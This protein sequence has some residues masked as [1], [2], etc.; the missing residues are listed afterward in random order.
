MDALDLLLTRE[1]ALKLAAPG[2]SQADLDAMFQSAVRAPDHGRLR[3]WHFV[4]IDTDRRAAFGELMAQS[5][6]RR[7][8]DAEDEMLDR[9]RA[10]AMRA[11][12]I[13]VTAAKVNKSAKIS[14]FEQIASAAAATQTLLLAANA[15]GFGAMWKTGDAAYDPDVKV[16]LGLAADDEIL[17][18][19]YVGTDV[20]GTSPIPRP[21]AAKYVSVW[22]G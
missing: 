19:L 15:K 20:G 12:T 16:A 22:Q 9:E 10:K 1:S 18:F 2:P 8:P 5:L 11:P 6:R 4:V 7:M 17:G 21:E 13:V 3:P 14:A